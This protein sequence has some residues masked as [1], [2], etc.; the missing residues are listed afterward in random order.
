MIR[1]SDITEVLRQRRSIRRYTQEHVPTEVI[2]KI[3]ESASYAPSAHNAQ[4]WRFIVITD[5]EQKETLANAMAQV[6][7]KELEDEHVPKNTRWATVNASVERFTSA[8]VL[9]LACFS[10]EDMDEYPDADRQEI[11]RDLAVQSLS[12]AIQNLLLAACE[13][14]LGGCWYCAPDFCQPAVIE[15][16]G[17][18]FDVEPLALIALGYPAEMPKPPERRPVEDF[19]FLNQWG[20]PI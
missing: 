7:F 15:A 3:L 16:M 1:M 5:A 19:A 6:W 14:G 8:P 11:E 10:M 17:M 2:R 4:P 20:N 9:I 12:A 13:K 18:P